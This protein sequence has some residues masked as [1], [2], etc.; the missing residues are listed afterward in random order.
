MVHRRISGDVSVLQ[1]GIRCN[2]S[3]SI[4]YKYCSHFYLIA[5]QLVCKYVFNT[6]GMAYF[7]RYRERPVGRSYYKRQQNAG[8]TATLRKVF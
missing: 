1:Y 4:L 7:R 5:L 3:L 6:S 2:A 8:N